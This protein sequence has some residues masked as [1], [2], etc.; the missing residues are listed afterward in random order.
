M[1]VKRTR[2]LFRVTVANGE[3]STHLGGSLPGKGVKRMD[4]IEL[5][6]LQHREVEEMFD[7]Y[8]D[9]DDKLAVFERIAD[10]LAVHAEIE[11][12]IFYPATHN[13]RT[14]DELQEAVQEHLQIKRLIAD[15][16]RLGPADKSFHAKMNVLREEIEHHVEEEESELFPAVR[17]SFDEDKLATLGEEM[18]ALAEELEEEGEPRQSVPSQIDEASP[19]P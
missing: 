11:E 7:E 18:E 10:A 19:L 15:L 16:L 14:D 13:E 17:A 6:E 5:L 9:S 12:K 4:A 2:G 8:E 3:R 1:G